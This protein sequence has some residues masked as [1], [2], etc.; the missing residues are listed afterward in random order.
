MS[1]LLTSLLYSYILTPFCWT[2]PKFRPTVT[3]GLVD[4][5]ALIVPAGILI[6]PLYLLVSTS[7]PVLLIIL[8]GL[9]QQVYQRR[10]IALPFWHSCWC[11][12]EGKTGAL[13]KYVASITVKPD[14]FDILTPSLINPR[15]CCILG[16]GAYAPSYSCEHT[17]HVCI[18]AYAQDAIRARCIRARYNIIILCLCVAPIG[19]SDSMQMCN[20]CSQL[21]RHSLFI[22]RSILPCASGGCR[23]CVVCVLALHE[24]TACADTW[25]GTSAHGYVHSVRL[26]TCFQ[27]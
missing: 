27:H 24:F 11:A 4:N 18:N 19:G 26:R 13:V 9:Q 17:V 2:F 15:H 25:V 12:W 10:S 22:P 20:V 7:R 23:V 14:S 3:C 1:Y 16:S 8:A 6:P 21:S 5:N